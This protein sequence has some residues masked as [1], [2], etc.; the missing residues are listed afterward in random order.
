MAAAKKAQPE[1]VTL[2]RDR[3]GKTYRTDDQTEIAILKGRG[4]RV[5]STPAGQTAGSLDQS[6]QG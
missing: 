5:R 3:D 1:K 2:V 6:V 4:F